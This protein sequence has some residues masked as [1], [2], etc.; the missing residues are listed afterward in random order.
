M[1]RR[2]SRGAYLLANV[3]L[4]ILMNVLILDGTDNMNCVPQRG[5]RFNIGV[6]HDED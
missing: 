4:D 2:E 5:Q 1:G 6:F 3:A